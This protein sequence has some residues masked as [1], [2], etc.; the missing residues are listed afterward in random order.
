MLS[1]LTLEDVR[2]LHLPGEPMLAFQQVAQQ[3]APHAFVAVAGY[4]DGDTGY[5][6]TE[7]SFAQGGYEP[8]GT[9]IA[10]SGEKVLK[11]ALEKLLGSSP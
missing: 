9:R 1:L 8:T 5:V 3:L 2:I 4:G 10:P 7:E 6:C 11:A